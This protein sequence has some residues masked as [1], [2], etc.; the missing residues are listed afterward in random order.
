M[1]TIENVAQVF[2][3]EPEEA[4]AKVAALTRREREVL[5]LMVQGETNAAIAE[6]LGISP[7]TLDIHRANIQKKTG[8]RPSGLGRVYYAAKLAA[9]APPVAATPG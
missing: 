6:A 8:T 9:F 2:E 1:I 4:A 3:I 7:K 5:D